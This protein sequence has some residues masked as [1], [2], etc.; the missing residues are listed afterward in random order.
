MLRDSDFLSTRDS[1]G[2]LLPSCFLMDF[3]AHNLCRTLGDKAKRT[4][5]TVVVH[6]H[7]LLQHG[8]R[9]AVDDAS[10]GS[11]DD[12]QGLI[13]VDQHNTQ[14][15]QFLWVSLLQTPAHKQIRLMHFKE[16]HEGEGLSNPPTFRT[17]HF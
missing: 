17:V 5:G 13:Q 3:V 16:K 11:F 14:S 1:G 8:L 15:W 6:H 9:R 7:D 12:R 4:I 2:L 10:Q